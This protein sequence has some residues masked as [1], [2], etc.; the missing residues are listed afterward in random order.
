MTW[1]MRE[2]AQHF[3]PEGQP[4]GAG[5]AARLRGI[6][7]RWRRAGYAAT[8]WLGSGPAW[9]WLAHIPAVLA[10]RV[11]LQGSDSYTAGETSRR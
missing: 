9:C 5:T 3:L 4:R 2:I 6:V 11:S 8:G 10:I 1:A 7:A